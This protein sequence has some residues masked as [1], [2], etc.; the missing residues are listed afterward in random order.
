M[1]AMTIRPDAA[2]ELKEAF[3]RVATGLADLLS[4]DDA[5]RPQRADVVLRWS[6]GA[7]MAISGVRCGENVEARDWIAEYAADKVQVLGFCDSHG[8]KGDVVRAVD[9]AKRHF[10]AGSKVTLRV[11]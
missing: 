9:L 11:D 6:R 7:S 10:P 3:F 2:T 1:G 5:R 4:P 8:I